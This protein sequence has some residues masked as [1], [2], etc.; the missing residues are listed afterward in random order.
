MWQVPVIVMVLAATAVPVGFRSPA[1]FTLGFDDPID[2]IANVLGYIHV[3]IV[4]GW[5]GSLHAVLAAA[6]M[7]LFTDTFQTV[8]QHRDPLCPILSQMW[9]VRSLGRP[10]AL[11][12]RFT[13]QAC[14]STGSFR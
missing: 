8:M 4:I 10:S 3:R 9:L 7:S 1:H 14:Q 5:L 6:G 13:G 12:G 2:A 11:V